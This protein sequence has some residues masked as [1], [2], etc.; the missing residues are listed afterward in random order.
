MSSGDKYLDDLVREIL[1]IKDRKRAI[2]FL[3]GI[4]TPQ[5]LEQIMKRLQ[6]VK[7]LKRGVSQREIA[8]ELDVGIATVTR[9]SREIRK[10]RFKY[11]K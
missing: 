11:V 8:E 9:G 7:M 1:R 3:Y 4:L 2:D 6:I 5:E 10:G